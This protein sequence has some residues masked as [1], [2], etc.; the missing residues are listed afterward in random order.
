[1]IYQMIIDHETSTAWPFER[2]L[3]FEAGRWP[4]GKIYEMQIRAAL[5]AMEEQY[6]LTVPV[7]VHRME[8]FYS[9]AAEPDRELLKLPIRGYVLAK[10]A[11]QRQWRK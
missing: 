7:P 4:A 2:Y 11:S 8:I 3:Y 9:L 5:E 6:L 10:L 1:M